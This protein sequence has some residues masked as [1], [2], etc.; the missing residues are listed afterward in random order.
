MSEKYDEETVRELQLST[1]SKKRTEH[2]LAFDAAEKQGEFDDMQDVIDW[3]RAPEREDLEMVHALQVRFDAVYD[4]P[5]NDDDYSN[6]K[7]EDY[8]L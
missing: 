5:S 8:G 4:Q 6:S 2:L 1:D 3:L 7:I